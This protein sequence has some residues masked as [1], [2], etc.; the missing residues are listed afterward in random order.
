MAVSLDLTRL[1]NNARVHLPG[2]I[3]VNLQLEFFNVLNDFFQNSNI[4]QQDI[5]FPVLGTDADP[6][7]YEVEQYGAASIVRLLWTVNSAGRPVGASMQTPGEILLNTAA[8][9]NDTLTATVSL[10]VDDPLTSDGYPEFPAWTLTKYG[11]GILEGLIGRMMAQPAKPYT[12][13]KLAIFHT[14][15]FTGAISQAKYEAL[16]RNVNNG[17]AWRFPQTFATRRR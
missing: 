6:T 10:T 15:K 5:E 8:T 12:N 9:V 7:T 3:D 14:R 4:W 11:T 17:Q 2:A 1:L 16:H 13:E